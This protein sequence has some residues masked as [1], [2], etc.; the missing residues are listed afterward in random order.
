MHSS[1]PAYTGQQHCEARKTQEIEGLL[2]VLLHKNWLYAKS[3]AASSPLLSGLSRTLRSAQ[4]VMPKYA[5]SSSTASPLRNFP[6]SGT[7]S[8]N[9]KFG[10][11]VRT[12]S[13][14]G[15]RPPGL[16]LRMIWEVSK[17]R[18][19]VAGS[20][21]PS[22]ASSSLLLSSCSSSSS[23]TSYHPKVKHIPGLGVQ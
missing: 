9:M 4:V 18:R 21:V 2:T 7:C 10:V 13:Q 5:I 3:N 12:C 6:S 8:H 22:S 16:E 15:L 23:H 17:L 14:Q 19:Y 1:P 20:A 11:T